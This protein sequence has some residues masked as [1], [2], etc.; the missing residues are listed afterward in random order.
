MYI[1]SIDL[2]WHSGGRHG[3]DWPQKAVRDFWTQTPGSELAVHNWFDH[4]KYRC[5]DGQ[6]HWDKEHT[7]VANHHWCD[8]E[9]GQRHGK[10]EG[11]EEP[12]PG[13]EALL[14]TGLERSKFEGGQGQV[15]DEEKVE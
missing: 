10:A 2:S 8:D 1:N 7:V 13:Q 15:P 3:K 5:S 9:G 14:Q 4:K 12:T 11:V 6:R